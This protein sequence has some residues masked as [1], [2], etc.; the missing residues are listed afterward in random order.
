MSDEKNGDDYWEAI[1]LFFDGINQ[2]SNIY[3]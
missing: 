3:Q 2:L 1:N